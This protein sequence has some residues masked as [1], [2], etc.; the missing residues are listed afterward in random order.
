MSS[1]LD[2]IFAFFF[3]FCPKLEIIYRQSLSNAY[4]RFCY[5]LS[6]IVQI[7][8]GEKDKRGSPRLTILP[9][10]AGL[11][12]VG[13]FQRR[14]R[15]CHLH[16]FMAVCSPAAMACKMPGF[17]RI[18][19]RWRRLRRAR[20][21][22]KTNC[23]FLELVRRLDEE[24]TLTIPLAQHKDKGIQSQV[25]GSSCMKLY[26]WPSK[27]INWWLLASNECCSFEITVFIMC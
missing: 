1:V 18:S 15:N 25:A 3:L 24:A 12:V 11:W 6:K 4:K 17:C 9:K 10:T 5:I 21:G 2:V 19:R 16:S 7:F 26:R 14:L 20:L 13:Q 22:S 8:P 27:L 23:T